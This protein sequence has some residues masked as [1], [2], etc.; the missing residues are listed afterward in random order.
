MDELEIR[1]LNTVAEFHQA[2]QV[3]RQIWGFVDVEVLPL[4]LLLTAQKNSG[5]VLGAF[6]NG[7]MVGVLFGFLGMT[8]TG[9]L[10]HCSHIM[11]VIPEYQGRGI[12]YLLKIKQRDYVLAQGLKL[13]TW[14][15]D[16][17]ESR[18]AYVNIHKLGAICRTYLP[19]LYGEIRD[20]LNKGLPSD[21][22]EVEWWLRSLRVEAKLSESSEEKAW[23]LERLEPVNTVDTASSSLLRPVSWTFEAVPQ[24][25]V[26]IPADFQQIRAQDNSLALAWRELSRELFARYFA[27]G[28]AVVEIFNSLKERRCFYLLEAGER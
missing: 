24:V 12:G 27:A 1:P 22:F 6:I 15:Y 7:E 20:D 9:K 28:Y 11:G 17:L 14:T 4:H 18:N 21:R 13:I 2:E 3:Q 26:E 19:N 5:L 25:L 8:A 10:K 16:P 23:S